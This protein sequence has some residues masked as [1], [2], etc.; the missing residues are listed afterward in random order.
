MAEI[1]YAGLGSAKTDSPSLVK[2]TFYGLWKRLT[3]CKSIS[4]M[5]YMWLIGAKKKGVLVRRKVIEVFQKIPIEKC[6]FTFTN[7]KNT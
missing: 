7:M 6:D 4:L 2:N 1:G 3:I 5:S